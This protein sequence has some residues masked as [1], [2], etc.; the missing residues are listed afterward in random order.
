MPR[1][2]LS[3]V[4]FVTHSLVVGALSLALATGTA[5]LVAQQLPSPQL[6]SIFP[7]G[8]QVGATIDLAIAGGDLD[9]ASQMLFSHPGIT[10]VKKE[11]AAPA[12]MLPANKGKK[13]RAS[14]VPSSHTFAVTVAG[15]V[16][17]GVYEARVVGRFGVSN[18]RTFVVSSLPEVIE[19]SGNN[20]AATAQAIAAGSTINGRADQNNKDFYKLPLKAGQRVIVDCAAER[21]DSKMDATLAIINP[22]G[23]EVAR[24]RDTAGKDPVLDFA[25]PADGDYTLL[26][27]DFTYGGGPE[28]SYRLAVH[29][30]PQV[31]FVF[32][33][34]GVPGSQGPFTIYGRNLPGGQP[35]GISFGGAML[36]KLTVNIP[37]P[38]DP[39]ALQKSASGSLKILPRS[40]FVD[41]FEYRLPAPQGASN[42]IAIGVATQPLVIEQDPNDTPDKAQKVTVPC[43][44]AGQ[45]YP[46]RDRDYVQFDAKKGDILMLEVLAHR[47]GIESDPALLIQRITKNDK[48]EETV[49]DVATVDD[50]PERQTRIGSDFDT[51]SDDPSYR[52]VVNDDATYRVLVRDNFGESRTDPRAVYRLIIRREQPD[53]RAA[54]YVD[55]PAMPANQNQV[56]LAGAALRRGGS[57]ELKISL[58][59]RDGFAG[60]VALSIEGLP[61]GVTCNGAVL[62]G[63]NER[64]SLVVAAADNVA[65]WSGA[66]R[67]VAKANI[68]GQ[69]VVREVRLGTLTWGTTDRNQRLPEF[70]VSR[71]LVLAVIDKELQPA[72]VSIGEE[73][74]YET[75]LGGNLEIPLKVTRREGCAD[76]I[77]LTKSGLPKEINIKEINIAAGANDGKVEMQLNQQ[78][79]QPGVYTFVMRGETKIKY[80]RNPDAIKAIE[81][82][83]TELVEMQKQLA[84]ALNK[85]NTDKTTATQQAQQATTERT[86]AEQAK[87]T[88]ETQS[89]QAATAAKAASD[90]AVQAKDAASK[91]AANQGLA[92]AAT[93][94]QKAADDAATAAKTAVDNLAKA[95]QALAA[96]D[97]KMKATAEAKTQAD[98]AAKEAQDAVTQATADKQ[99]LDQRVTEVKNQNQPKDMQVMFASLPV[100]VRI[101]ATPLKLTAASPSAAVKQGDKLEL[102]VTIERLF[103][104]ADTVEVVLESPGVNGLTVPKADIPKD[105][106]Q[107]KLMLTA[108][109]DAT[110]GEHKVTIRAKARFNN[111]QVET[112]QPLIVNIEKVEVK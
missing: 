49:S 24:N 34:A 4:R 74:I 63:N 78:N 35:A 62:G 39:A 71:D 86:Q 101:L 16:P 27:Y 51:S 13:G 96:A 6:T 106:T 75:S 80:A 98:L 59:R 104:F 68:N 11:E 30:A 66:V 88:A 21:I 12:V 82:E 33:P 95:D 28:H 61:A 44:V 8:G 58:D 18:P 109:K 48:G 23:R 1:P 42:P 38:G 15:N 43:E 87:K 105:Q 60:D 56:P 92:A 76:A 54:V 31:D 20:T 50:L 2:Y 100:K 94:A 84:E 85:A 26:V 41:S 37:V 65:A 93:A 73:K 102:P 29:S 36:E 47:L 83:Q 5:T 17:P 9:E 19:A 112:T 108:G 103:G 46:Q 25:A 40:S 55:A 70:R 67:I 7:P 91:D 81:G 72:Q 97:A 99:K 64:G 111:V 52:L 45:F 10:A 14:A 57:L 79:I 89:Q 77:K 90:K 110:P 3:A 69:D 22:A 32:P 53:F 107:G